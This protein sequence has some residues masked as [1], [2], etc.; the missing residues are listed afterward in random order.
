MFANKKIIVLITIIAITSFLLLLSLFLSGK[1]ST[2]TPSGDIPQQETIPSP[3]PQEQG[4]ISVSPE[5]AVELIPGEAQTFVLSFNQT[6][7][8]SDIETIITKVDRIKDINPKNVSATTSFRNSNKTLVIALDE[9]ISENTKYTL[10][11][12]E[13]TTNTT[14]LSRT[15]LSGF[16]PE[17]PTTAN[18]P[19]LI[20]YLPYQTA[21]FELI[22]DQATND[23]V[24]HFSYN[25]NSPDSAATQYEEAKQAAIRFIKSKGVD[26]NKITI[27][28]KYS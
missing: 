5:G 8:P 19:A 7:L 10:T 4:L 13:K 6:L 14:L 23:Y 24:F 2:P 25:P 9:P 11:I 26:P 15:Y 27:E 3:K 20:K 18:D 16:P 21:S 1:S 28:W 12:K 22:F 17:P